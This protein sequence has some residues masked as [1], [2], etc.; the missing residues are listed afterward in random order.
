MRKISSEALNKK[1]TKGIYY[2]IIN[3]RYYI[4]KDV[5]IE[6]KRRIKDHIRDLNT[7]R[8]YNTYLQ[9]AYNK[10]Q[11]FEFGVLWK[12]KCSLD[13]LSEKEIF[14]IAKYD[15]YQNGYNLTIGGEGGK[16]MKYTKEQLEAKSERVTGEKNPVSKLTNEQ[17]FEIVELLKKGKTNKEIADIYELHDRYVSLIRHK[18]RFKKLWEKVND[19][20]PIKSEN[21]LKARGKVTEEMFLDIVRMLNEGASNA[22]IERK[23]SL[24]AGTGS[25][26]RHKKLYKQ[27]W[28]RLV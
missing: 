28:E 8:H 13:E 19:Y 14:Y 7:G 12:G 3:D 16:G 23:H 5:Y 9:R 4:G 20:T 24:S 15:S 1:D 21:Q 26:I 6:Q 25:R 2:L 22:E 10:H 17:F 18:K 27:W 11:S